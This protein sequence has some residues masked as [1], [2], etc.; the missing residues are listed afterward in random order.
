MALCSDEMSSEDDDDLF[1]DAWLCSIISKF[2][3]VG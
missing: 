1:G 3:A 2:L